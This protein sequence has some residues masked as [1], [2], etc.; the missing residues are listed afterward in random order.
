KVSKTWKGMSVAVA[1]TRS[2]GVPLATRVRGGMLCEMATGTRVRTIGTV[3]EMKSPTRVGL[4]AGG[5]TSLPSRTRTGG[6]ALS[7]T[8][9]TWTKEVLID[10]LNT[11]ATAAGEIV[12]KAVGLEAAAPL[13]AL[14][15]LVAVTAGVAT[16]G[17]AT[18]DSA[19]KVGL[20]RKNWAM[21]LSF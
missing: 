18:S 21:A 4:K 8:S 3:C 7:P 14:V 13:A 2:T 6:G 16:R 10:G 20:A 19:L 11:L 1:R 17:V 12:A 5:A 9:T 15:A